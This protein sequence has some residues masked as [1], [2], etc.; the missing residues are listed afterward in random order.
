MAAVSSF[1]IRSTET[2]T[3]VH[4]GLME[5]DSVQCDRLVLAHGQPNRT[6]EA[7]NEFGIGI[8]C[9]F[10]QDL[11][12]IIVYTELYLTILHYTALYNGICGHECT[13]FVVG[14]AEEAVRVTLSLITAT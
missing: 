12:F 3:K 14:L 4:Y 11:H 13:E 8:C 7:A 10:S 6:Q 9:R 2:K 5:C 1:Y